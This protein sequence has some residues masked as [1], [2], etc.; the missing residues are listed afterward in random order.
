MNLAELNQSALDE[1]GGAG[2]D[3]SGITPPSAIEPETKAQVV[4]DPHTGTDGDIEL[5]STHM[6]D[7][8][9][10]IKLDDEEESKTASLGDIATQI[11]ATESINRSDVLDFINRGKALLKEDP[12]M[13]FAQTVFPL[14][15]LTQEPSTM[16]LKESQRFFFNLSQEANTRLDEIRNNY[17]LDFLKT[18]RLTLE[19]TRFMALKLM[20]QLK[21][22]RDVLEEAVHQATTSENRKNF[23]FYPYKDKDGNVEVNVKAID[24]RFCVLS[25]SGIGEFFDMIQRRHDLDVFMNYYEDCKTMTLIQELGKKLYVE[26]LDCGGFVFVPTDLK[27]REFEGGFLDYLFVIMGGRLENYLE[28]IDMAAQRFLS[29]NQQVTEALEKVNGDL[30]QLAIEE[31]GKPL[32]FNETLGKLKHTSH[33]AVENANVLIRIHKLISAF[34]PFCQV[35]IEIFKAK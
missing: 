25:S 2:L 14:N 26:D 33:G 22:N 35:M 28:E 4:V 30:T 10:L 32:Q 6:N 34:I 18:H 5:L 23:L 13:T 11:L 24:L 21:L 9:V 7:L 15:G 29:L 31:D 1:L 8:E 27:N 19:S 20:D 12:E 3:G 16:G 17:F